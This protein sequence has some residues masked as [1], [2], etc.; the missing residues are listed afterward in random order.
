MKP[1]ELLQYVAAG[2]IIL[3]I[4]AL[5]VTQ[6]VGQPFIVFV[7]TGSMEPTLQPNDGFIAI[8]AFFAG[9]PQEGD[10]ILFQAQELGGGE[11]TTHRVVDRTERGYITKGDANP[12]LDQD[13]D[14]PP[15]SEGQIKSVALTINGEPVIIPGLGASITSLSNVVATFQAQLFGFFGLEAP[16]VTTFSMGILVLGLVL[17]VFSLTGGGLVRQARDRS[18]GS[19][20]R[21]GVLIIAILTLVVIIPVNFSMLLP[22]GVYQIEMV[23]AV[24][25]AEDPRIIQAGESGEVTYF[26]QNSGHLPVVVF[27]RPAGDGVETPGDYTYVPRRTTINR[28]VTLHAP[29]ETGTYLRYV[30]ESRYLVVLPPSLIAALHHINPLLALLAINVTVAIAVIL[31]SLATVGTGRVRLRSRRREIAIEDQ[32]RRRLPPLSIGRDPPSR[33]TVSR[34]PFYNWTNRRERVDAKSVD[35]G[36]GRPPPGGE[37]GPPP[38]PQP[39][40]DKDPSRND[41]EEDDRGDARDRDAGPSVPD[42]HLNGRQLIEV[43]QTLGDPPDAVGLDETRWTPELLQ[44]YLIDEYGVGYSLAECAHLLERSGYEPD[45]PDT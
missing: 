5:L 8:P 41:A 7:E 17:F 18:K 21:N 19:L 38:G 10:I 27:I 39:G 24:S 4:V 12:F 14:E 28:S 35:P 6:L 20:L 16:G 44:E 26:M 42:N 11:L 1:T 31:V 36:F 23:S 32:L 29:N 2:T 33:P 3:L 34:D 9:Q 13:G 37:S 22:S 40:P 25:S 30:R 45:Y 43:Y 15:V